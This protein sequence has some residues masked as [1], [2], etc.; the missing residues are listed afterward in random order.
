M[1][2]LVSIVVVGHNNWP[3]L[4]LSVQSALC[5]SYRPSE[6]ILV[7][8]SSTDGTAGEVASR[9]GSRVR[10]V[11]QANRGDAGAARPEALARLRRARGVVTPVA[12]IAGFLTVVAPGGRMLAGSPML[13]GLR[14]LASRAAG[15]Q[16]PGL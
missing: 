10:Y 5:Q 2:P 16:A 8:N 12:Y 13:G 4:E 11:L 6:V 3:D 14:R 9:F 15:Y 1:T 7:D